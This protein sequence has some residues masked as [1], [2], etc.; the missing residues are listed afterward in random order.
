MK[1]ISAIV[2]AAGMGT[3]MKSGLVKVMHPVAGSPMIDWSV[4]AAFAAGVERCVLVV[5][6]QQEKVR[7]FFGGRPE[8]G[9]ALQAEQLGTGHAVRCAMPGIDSDAETVLILCG[10]TPLLTADSLRDMLAAHGQSGACV[11]VMTATLDNPFGY[12]RI[13]KDADGK[14]VAITEQKDASEAE[15]L[16]REVN[17]GVYCVDRAFLAEAVDKLDNDNAQKEYYL[18]DVVRQ[19]NAR[20]LACR[21]FQVS[22]PLEISGVNDRVQMAEAA[23]VLRRRINRELM[24]SGVTIIDPGAV[25][26]DHG[27]KIG[28]D[29]VVYPGAV[30]KGNTVIG[31]RCKIGQN[32]L[33]E[34][35]RIADD[36][37]VKAGSVLEDSKVGPEAAI[38]PMAH[39]RP[40]T[41]L[42]AQVKIGNFVET[43]KAFMGEGSKASHLT[44]LGDATIGRDVNIGCGTIT[45]NYDGVNKHKTVIE[46]GVFV[47]SDV[48]LVAP[49]TVGKNSLIA[50]GT[51]V[52]KDVPADSLAIARSPQVNKEGWTLRKK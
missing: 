37:V 9:F 7:D 34:G 6:H 21:S 30:I 47:G 1:K 40:G 5:G 20:G 24:L 43:K 13:V 39:L 32:T 29:S 35:C 46:D 52:T 10:D 50:A 27:V 28:R 41:E 18:T 38:G 23:A 3:R 16:I 51:T 15:R 44:Y 19:A 4:A 31:E 49:V 36:V 22:D 25:Y 14:V 45:C 48:Q 33:I 42:S 8:V 17:A 12:G 11:T 26:I 2:L